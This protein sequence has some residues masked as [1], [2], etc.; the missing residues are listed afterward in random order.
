MTTGLKQ[1]YTAWTKAG[2]DAAQLT[3]T[4][5][6]IVTT[7]AAT[8]TTAMVAYVTYDYTAAYWSGNFDFTFKFQATAAESGAIVYPFA[9]GNATVGAVGAKIVAADNMIV[10][11]FD[12][13]TPNMTLIEV[14]GGVITNAD[15]SATMA[16]ATT[17]YIRVVRDMAASANGTIYA[18]IYTDPEMTILFDWLSVTAGE[19]VVASRSYRYFYA[20]SSAGV[21]GTQKFTGFVQYL[22]L[23]PNAYSLKNART[24]ARDLLNEATANFWTDTE[25]TEFYNDAVRDIAQKTGCIRHI[26]ALATASGTRYIA[27]NGYSVE[28]MEYI[29][30]RKALAKRDVRSFGRVQSNDT[31]PQWFMDFGTRVYIEPLPAATETVLDAYISDYSTGVVVGG[32][33]PADITV[34]AQLCEIPPAFRPLIIKYMFYRGLLKEGRYAAAQ[35]VYSMY[36]NEL[37]FTMQDQLDI[38]PDSRADMRYA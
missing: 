38:I 17:Y 7:T 27:Y 26:D 34:D 18:Y 36:W 15:T 1:D 5:D 2:A 31:K 24:R 32:T 22:V 29:T 28:A 33:A 19:T 14:D 12:G 25:L 21:A 4:A 3:A 11:K 16:V 8:L 6:Q 9:L 30:T 37:V 35:Q 13:T 10:L 23:D 20:F